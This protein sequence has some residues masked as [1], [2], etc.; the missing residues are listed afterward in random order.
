M[1][2]FSFE[3]IPKPETEFDMSSL[4]HAQWLDV[5]IGAGQGLHAI[6]HASQNPGRMLL[7]LEKTHGRFERLLRRL[8]NHPEILNLSAI[9]TDAVAF[10]SHFI[11]DGKIDQVFL[12]YPNPYPKAKQANLRWHN[13][14]FMDLLLRKM[15][16]G[17]GLTLA[18]NMEW[19][20]NEALVQ[21]TE[22]WKMELQSVA[23]ISPEAA[24]RTH[25]EK[26]YLARG[27]MCWNLEFRKPCLLQST[28]VQ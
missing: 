22:T 13:R 28:P 8:Q 15:R 7:A 9:H 18:T 23:P 11:P 27:E 6:H 26:K 25:F 12:L 4:A 21:M 5:E 19:Y 1:R 20:K 3:H 14:P 2:R 24:P 10:I 17:A 16:P